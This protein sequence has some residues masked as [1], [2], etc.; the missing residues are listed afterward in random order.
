MFCSPPA[1][2]LSSLPYLY[3]VTNLNNMHVLQ[4][5]KFTA[6]VF[7][8]VQE[9]YMSE[10]L[11]LES[12]GY[13]DNDDVIE[14]LE[15]RAGGRSGIIPQLNEEC[16]IPKGNEASYISKLI[17]TFARH[18]CFAHGVHLGR[19]EFIVHH[20]AGAVTYSVGGF[21]DRNKD[22]L[23]SETRALML[24][25]T[26]EVIRTVFGAPAVDAI[27]FLLPT[28]GPQLGERGGAGDRSSGRHRTSRSSYMKVTLSLQSQSWC[29]AHDV[30]H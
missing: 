26:N 17:N 19:D 13:K 21:L 24:S 29:I 18:P 8:A 3:H 6:D 20:Y 28:G 30:T 23:P 4:Q 11:A 7:R 9:E 1:H 14:L 27:D 25:S 12:I 2:L 15:G 5:Q 22:S 10:G 16:L